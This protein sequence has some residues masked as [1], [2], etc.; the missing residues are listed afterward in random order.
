MS[1][2]GA[3]TTGAAT[4]GAAGTGA[5]DTTVAATGAPTSAPGP[6]L[7]GRLTFRT[8]WGGP[9]REGLLEEAVRIKQRLR[10]EAFSYD[11]DLFLTVGGDITP[12]EGPSGLRTPR[13]S[14][15]RR[16][17][18]GEIHVGR[19]EASAAP[20][21]VEFLR[22][23]IHAA[24]FALLT[25]VAAKDAEVDVATELAKIVFLADGDH[26]SAHDHQGPAAGDQGTQ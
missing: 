12:G 1:D 18:T 10:D 4:T 15:A 20:D 3:E 7:T 16:R 21:P 13:V 5:T 24:L 8:V 23:T 26:G 9:P 2:H 17:A 19:D 14:L 25:R 6:A 22:H 11:L